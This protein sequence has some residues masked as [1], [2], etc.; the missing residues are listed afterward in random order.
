L[1]HYL[2][3]YKEILIY[4]KNPCQAL[5]STTSK[6]N[7]QKTL[8]K[9]EKLLKLGLYL[10]YNYPVA[11][12]EI[13]EHQSS[14]A[15][16]ALHRVEKDYGWGADSYF[17][18]RSLVAVAKTPERIKRTRKINPFVSSLTEI[19]INPKLLNILIPE[20]FESQIGKTSIYPC[21]FNNGS[22]KEIYHLKIPINNEK[23][24]ILFHYISLKLTGLQEGKKVKE[25]DKYYQQGLE[26]SYVY[27]GPLGDD[28][29][30][31][32]DII[33]LAARI[34]VAQSLD[35]LPKLCLLP[36]TSSSSELYF[37]KA[38]VILQEIQKPRELL[39]QINTAL[40]PIGNPKKIKLNRQTELILFPTA[41]AAEAGLFFAVIRSLS[42]QQ[43]IRALAKFSRAGLQEFSPFL[44]SNS[45][46]LSFSLRGVPFQ[47]NHFLCCF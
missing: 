38:T 13:L 14:P 32:R 23:G 36:L 30:L 12:I 47:A 5:S 20:E 15:T 21:I 27:F 35:P 46:W 37:K 22:L 6:T 43:R 29:S 3:S 34:D 39:I 2:F 9:S 44:A 28:K 17:E 16:L 7:Q 11:R 10:C 8:C 24:G 4:N 1:N 19:K 41:Y 25:K 45:D 40:Y 26:P 18:Q 33:G 31:E 42:S